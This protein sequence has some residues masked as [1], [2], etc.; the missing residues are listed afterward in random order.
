MGVAPFIHSE[1]SV[2]KP[3]PTTMP[4]G[5]VDKRPKFPPDHSFLPELRQRV[6]SYFKTNRLRERDSIWMYL[7]T[8]MI[9]SWF[10]GS[11][12]MLVFFA[13]TWWQGLLGAVSLAFSMAGVGFAIQHDG[14]H[15]G[16]SNSE[17][18]N[19]LAAWTLDLIGASS[20]L[21]YWKHAIFHHT[22]V[23]VTGQDTD[24]DVGNLIRLSPHQPRRWYH[25]WQQFYLWPLYGLMAI[26]WHLYGDFRDALVGT[27]GPHRIPR[28]KG[29]DLVVFAVGKLVSVG[30]YF[31][32]PM[33]F[34][35][36]WMVLLFYV[37][38]TTITSIIMSIVFQLAHCVEDADFPMPIEGTMR[39]E[40]AWSIHQVETTV[41]FARGSRILSWYLGGLNFQIVHHLFPKICH[42]HYPALSKIVEQTC[43]EFGVRYSFHKT[44]WAGI[45]SHYRFL[46]EL[47]RADTTS[48]LPQGA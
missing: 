13:E 6:D 36:W 33:F 28:P 17:S 39:M 44:F 27:I 8:F 25:R 46:R 45:V 37:I 21:W 15:H 48:P 47:G 16:Y 23:N 38:V 14:G 1:A 5:Q 35:P 7:K 10:A 31:V 4:G 30:L 40:H 22:Y 11:Y 2:D 43:K 29:W 32:L 41:D 20:Y 42:I 34:F 3:T 18:I 9:L 24:I 26:R 19:K 12:I